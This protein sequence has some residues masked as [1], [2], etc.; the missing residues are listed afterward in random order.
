[1]FFIQTELPDLRAPIAPAG[2]AVFVLSGPLIA[3]AAIPSELA[4]TVE[5]NPAAENPSDRLDHL[6]GQF[7]E[8]FGKL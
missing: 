6:R 2:A 1:L 3:Y 8:R 4:L 7:R 5:A